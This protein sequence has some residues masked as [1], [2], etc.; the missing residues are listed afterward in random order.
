MA[1][2]TVSALSLET[3]GA[4]SAR[5]EVDDRAQNGTNKLQYRITRELGAIPALKAARRE[6]STCPC[7]VSLCIGRSLAIRPDDD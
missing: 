5:L 1:A 4:S 7:L 2:S 6:C 3:S